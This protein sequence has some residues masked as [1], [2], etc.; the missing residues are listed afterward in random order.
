MSVWNYLMQ[1]TC[2]CGTLTKVCI[3]LLSRNLLTTPS[4]TPQ[5]KESFFPEMMKNHWR[6]FFSEPHHWIKIVKWCT[7]QAYWFMLQTVTIYL[8]FF[9]TTFPANLFKQPKSKLT[10]RLHTWLGR[11]WFLSA[12][13]F[14]FSWVVLLSWVASH[15]L[16]PLL[17]PLMMS[18]GQMRTH[19]F[20]YLAKTRNSKSWQQNWV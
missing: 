5:G 7:G 18:S 20:S 2:T 13:S 16:L 6:F 10:H 12:F 4:E 3:E 15:H 1:P 14:S 19:S 8:Q 11:R 17:H 9:N